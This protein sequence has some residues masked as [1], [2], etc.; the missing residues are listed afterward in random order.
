M[1][2]KK[3]LPKKKKSSKNHQNRNSRA[4]TPETG[5]FRAGTRFTPPNK[6]EEKPDSGLRLTLSLVEA[7]ILEGS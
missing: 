2:K 7:S 1:T 5:I 4:K 3:A 6:P